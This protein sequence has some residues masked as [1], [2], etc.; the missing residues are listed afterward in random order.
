[1]SR[2]RP[3]RWIAIGLVAAATA[4]PAPGAAQYV[5]PA[6]WAFN[7]RLRPTLLGYDAFSDLLPGRFGLAIDVGTVQ[8]NNAVSIADIAALAFL[9]GENSLTAWD[10]ADLA[11]EV[12]DA[13][14]V[15]VFSTATAQLDVTMALGSLTLGLHA[16]GR[17]YGEARLEEGFVTLLTA[18]NGTLRSFDLE[19][20]GGWGLVTAEAG[21]RAVYRFDAGL[22][23]PYFVF[24][25]GA[26]LVRPAALV[27]ADLA[28]AGRI[29]V[30]GDSLVA[31]LDAEVYTTEFDGSLPLSDRL[32][33]SGVAGSGFAVDLMARAEWTRTAVEL[34]VFDVGSVSVRN[35]ERQTLALDYAVTTVDSL[36]TL[37][38]ERKANAAGDTLAFVTRGIA[39]RD[40]TLPWTVRGRV[41]YEARPWL[42]VDG[43]LSLRSA[44]LRRTT[45]TEVGVT[46]APLSW[47]PLRASAIVD[48]TGV[49]FGGG[50]TLDAGPVFMEVQA[51][52]LSGFL[53][54]GRGIGAVY[55]LMLR[56]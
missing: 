36:I 28:R 46:L 17:E 3:V 5:P 34:A 20:S 21:A 37:L 48:G 44:R 24:G 22:A 38:D 1:M 9:D 33:D 11:G 55:R 47:L 13:G 8:Q 6:E 54:Q 23:G 30:S 4:V 32:T 56:L 26:R 52:T 49:G 14:D 29:V 41:A 19:G 50:V 16:G 10:V 7:A 42:Y 12:R 31:R 40:V 53:D 15:T 18:G 27:E 51:A 25:G 43:A 35:V 2:R 39:E 45:R